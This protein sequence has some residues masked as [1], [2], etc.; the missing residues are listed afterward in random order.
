MKVLMLNGSPRANGNTSIALSEMDKIFRAEGI[1]TEILHIGNMD[2]RGCT[3]C[4]G[5]RKIG[6]C[7]YDDVVNTVAEKADS[8]KH[9]NLHIFKLVVFT[10]VVA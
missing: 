9:G 6:K 2:I 7:V 10:V 3:A 1:E 4:G 8:V 5:C